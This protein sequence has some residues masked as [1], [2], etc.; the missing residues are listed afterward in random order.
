[1][2]GPWAS[3]SRGVVVG[4]WANRPTDPPPYFQYLATDVG[5][6]GMLFY[7]DITRWRVWYPSVLGEI[8]TIVTG[9]AQTA[10]QYIGSGVNRL[11][12][13]PPGVLQVGDV[14]V[15][16]FSVGKTGG[17]DA[18]GTAT[19]ILLGQN[20]DVSDAAIATSNISGT[21][22]AARRS[23][24]GYEKWFRVESPTTIRPIGSLNMD[25]TFSGIFTNNIAPETTVGIVNVS[26]IPWRIGVSTTMGGA[27]DSPQLTY[28]RLTLMP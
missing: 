22:I 18:F 20:G 17:T 11:G 8:G 24:P 1:M 23:G 15:Y 4:T 19:N 28:Q 21:M 12:P 2:S 3:Q 26:T 9:V 5:R 6:S 10:N 7:W 25:P 13:F 27:T 14:L 16:Q